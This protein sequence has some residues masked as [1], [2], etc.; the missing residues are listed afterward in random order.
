M[1]IDLKCVIFKFNNLKE[2]YMK[3]KRILLIAIA[4]IVLMSVVMG[5]LVACNL[6]VKI[7]NNNNNNVDNGI[8]DD[9]NN[10]NDN[11]NN[12]DIESKISITV[13]LI[14]NKQIV[15][16]ERAFLGDVLKDLKAE[17][18]IQLEY[19]KSAYGM[20]ITSINGLTLKSNEFVGIY[21][22]SDDPENADLLMPTVTKNGI[23]YYSSNKGADTLPIID[24]MKYY[25]AITKSIF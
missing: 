5:T 15:T 1:Q 21:L 23:T 2:V 11:E 18:L 17:G 7:D 20:F 4:I 25:L 8:T 13:T 3:N 24:G 9:S 22:S 6:N 10:N 12:G 16:T 14:D 19:Q